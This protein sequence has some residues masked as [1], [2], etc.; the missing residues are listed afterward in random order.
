[1]LRN[2]PALET[3]AMKVLYFD[4][5]SGAS[6]DMVL[7]AL[8]DAGASQDAVRGALNSLS[9]PGWSLTVDETK[10]NGI[11]GLRAEVNAPLQSRRSYSDIKTLLQSAD[12]DE[13]IRERSGEVFL[14]LAEAEAK[15]HGTSVEDVHFHE[16]G[17]LDA[18]I[19]I[20]GSCAA[21]ADLAPDLIVCSPIRTGTGV[22]PT[23]HG[24]LPVPVPAVTELLD[25]IPVEI[26]GEGESLTPTGAALLATFSDRSGP[27]PRLHLRATGYGAGAR[28]PQ[29]GLPNLLRVLIGD[30]DEHDGYETHLVVETNLDDMLPE[31]IPY[32]IERSMAA[33]AQ[34]VWTYPIVMKKG[35]P[36]LTLSALVTPKTLD[37]VLDV[38]YEETTTLGVRISP[39]AKRELHREW[40][41][42]QVEGYDVRI[43]VGQRSGRVTTASPE[44]EDAAKVARVTG[45]PLKEIYA[46]ALRAL[47]NELS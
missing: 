28:D 18:I 13:E 14:A 11:R 38:L 45:I 15:V 16:V 1:M 4:C 9:L 42:V 6:G 17:A 43:K 2:A 21:V 3:A 44:Y 19:D 20:V 33:G 39:A 23:D 37:A 26:S 5:F 34:D 46:R 12:L 27:P 29:V 30:A 22:A 25:E 10:R 41:T 7:G 24:L 32:V 31:L 47:P 40:R 8:L 36:A 35:R